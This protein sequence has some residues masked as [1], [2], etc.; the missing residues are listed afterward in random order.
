MK[1]EK[2]FYWIKNIIRN[3]RNCR[4]FCVAC[5]YYDICRMEENESKESGK[6]D[7]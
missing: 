4:H 7:Y 5:E 3:K 2:F 6:R 1:I